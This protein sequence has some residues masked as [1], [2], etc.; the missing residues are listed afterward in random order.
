MPEMEKQKK[1]KI[2]ARVP[3]GYEKSKNGIHSFSNLLLLGFRFCLE[4]DKEAG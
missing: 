4:S 1:W 3:K 2:L